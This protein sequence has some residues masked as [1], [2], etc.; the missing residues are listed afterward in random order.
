LRQRGAMD[1]PLLG[2]AAAVSK[3][4]SDRCVWS[5]V[6]LTGVGRGPVSVPEAGNLFSGQRLDDGLVSQVADAAYELARPV[7]NVGSD[8]SYRRK[9]VRALTIRA[10]TRAWGGE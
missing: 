1:Y 4:G 10:L 2:V 5:R 8:A 3:D 7:N 6:T 9:M